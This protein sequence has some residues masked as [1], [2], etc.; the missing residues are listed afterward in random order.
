MKG[1]GMPKASKKLIN[2]WTGQG[3]KIEPG[4]TR[5]DIHE[6]ESKNGVTMPQDLRDYFQHVNGMAQDARNSCDKQGFAFWPLCQVKS[7]AEELADQS[8]DMPEIPNQDR[9]F[10]FADYL[11]R[12][13]AYAIDFGAPSTES[14]HVIHVG[15]LKFKIVAESFDRFVDLYVRDAAELYPDA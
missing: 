5:Q 7:V 2:H 15:T 1:D 9:Y 11:Q 14:A 4:V 3:L 10:V 6:F 13:W 8:L 12:S